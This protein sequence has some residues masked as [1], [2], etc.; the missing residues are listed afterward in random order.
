M[1]FTQSYKSISG[2][3]LR[4]SLCLGLV[5]PV[6]AGCGSGDGK[7]PVSG[8]VKLGDAPLAGATVG[9]I[10]NNGGQVAHALTDETGRFT[11]RATPGINKVIVNKAEDPSKLVGGG[12]PAASGEEESA[13]MLA[14]VE[15]GTQSAKEKP[16]EWIVDQKFASPMTSGF[17]FDIKAG[18]AEIELVVTGP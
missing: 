2:N 6:L 1:H 17:E 9:F 10:G 7:I 3:L 11:V 8:L 15:V 18:M 16:N 13:D 12:S 14:G 4:W 5:I